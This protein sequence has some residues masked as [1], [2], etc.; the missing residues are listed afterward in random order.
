MFGSHFVN[1]FFFLLKFDILYGR[2]FFGIVSGL[3]NI[4]HSTCDFIYPSLKTVFLV[5][6]V[7]VKMCYYDNFPCFTKHVTL[8]V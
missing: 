5:A 6:Y 7:V 3:R 4:V 8:H 2:V 1:T